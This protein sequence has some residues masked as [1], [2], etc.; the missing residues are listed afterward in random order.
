M[1]VIALA[2]FIVIADEPYTG[3]AVKQAVLECVS[4]AA[5]WVRNEPKCQLRDRAV[6]IMALTVKKALRSPHMT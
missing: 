5:Y 4:G 3:A 2:W 6:V 1:P